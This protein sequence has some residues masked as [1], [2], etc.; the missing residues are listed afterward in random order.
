MGCVNARS[1]GNKSAIL[2]RTIADEQLDILVITETWHE[3][4]GSTVLKNVTPPG[5]QCIDA[6]RPIPLDARTDTVDFQNYGGLAFIHRQNVKFQKR[7]FDATVTTFE[8]LCVYVSIADGHFILL[9]VYRPGS[10]GLTTAFFDELSAIFER[11][12]IYK[13][14]VVVCGDFNIH[15]DKSDDVHTVRLLQLL[16]TFGCVQHVAESTHTAGHILDL[17]ITPADTDICDLSVGSMLSDH[18]LICFTLR[19]ARH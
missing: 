6:A 7:S 4:S 12:M 14:P 2:C 9:G 1:A 5:Y 11:L 18:A 19:V 17:V 10:Q 16:Q 15:V 13:C 8:Y 3:C